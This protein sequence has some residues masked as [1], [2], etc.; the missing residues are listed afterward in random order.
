MSSAT[1]LPN[2]TAM[3][4]F[5][6]KGD[7]I[8]ERNP[9]LESG[10][11]YYLK[12]STPP[13]DENEAIITGAFLVT[14]AAKSGRTYTF[15]VPAG[16]VSADGLSATG[17][18]GGIRPNGLDYTTGDTDFAPTTSTIL[19]GGKIACGIPAVLG[20]LIRSAIQGA[21]QTGSATLDIGTGAS[22]DVY[23]K[24]NGNPW[25]KQT[26][27]GIAQYWNGSSYVAFNDSIASSLVK[28][29]ATDTTPDYLQGKV[30][31]S[32]SSIV[33]AV[34]GSGADETL[35]MT[36]A[37]PA[38]ISSHA[39]YTPA[40]M[41][42]GNSAETTIALW[43]SL[44]GG[45]A[46]AFGLSLDGTTWQITGCDMTGVTTMAQVA[47]V[48]QTRIRAITGTL[49]TCTW[50]GGNHFLITSANTT[51][52]SSVGVLV[53]PSPATGTD[54]SG[55]GAGTWMD[56]ETG[57]GTATAAVLNPA[58][59]SGKVGLLNARGSYP[60]D[61]ARDIIDKDG[62]SAAG[63]IMVATAA[64][65]PEEQ[66]I[67]TE[68]Q[69][70]TVRLANS[71]KL[72]WETYEPYVIGNKGISS[73]YTAPLMTN[74]AIPKAYSGV[75]NTTEPNGSIHLFMGAN[76]GILCPDLSSPA[77][78]FTEFIVEWR[79]IFNGL[80]GGDGKLGVAD[81]VGGLTSVYNST[82]NNFIGFAYTAGGT[83]GLYA[84][85]S[86]GSAVTTTLVDAG[87]A[88]GEAKIF[89]IR[90]TA[91]AIYFYINNSL[92]ATHT[93]NIPTVT[94]TSTAW[95]WGGSSGNSGASGNNHGY[96]IESPSIS[97][98]L[99]DLYTA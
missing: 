64:N 12:W 76:N 63:A 67:G 55:A 48:I 83:A 38:R 85:N 28:V 91:S 22:E 87:Y 92:V 10:G 57:R 58:A 29:S 14:G 65:T 30:G 77:P 37:L 79:G 74:D 73:Y 41:T 20:E 2:S 6:W 93:T 68:G 95:G 46:G 24:H 70:L 99:T 52:S 16:A 56:S 27:A 53:S 51:S 81:V 61:L 13:K 15:W 43:D 19:A 47:S 50:E 96:A 71:N 26:S 97:I 60:A 34:T 4:F 44:T 5:D 35:D 7:P 75:S 84:V 49:A 88:S 54:I 31:S 17:C 1:K 94:V 90:R 33:F 3:K 40:Y 78:T 25:L 18:V 21:I 89:R 86:N 39:I 32:D 9:S 82:A 45:N 11:T 8:F 72:A 98:L 36:T 62:Y 59:D 42:G 69:L 80:N 66:L 23:I